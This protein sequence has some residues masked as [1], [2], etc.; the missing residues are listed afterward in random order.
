MDAG[1]HFQIINPIFLDSFSFSTFPL[2]P[3]EIRDEI[4][5][6]SLRH[7]R[8]INIHIKTRG[9]LPPGSETT[10]LDD[11]RAGDA[12]TNQRPKFEECWQHVDDVRALSKLMRVNREA[13]AC[14]LRFYR[15]HIPCYLQDRSNLGIL[16]LNPEN[17][18]INIQTNN[19]VE[20]IRFINKLRVND[21]LGIGPLNL[22]VSDGITMALKDINKLHLESSHFATF[23]DTLKNLRQVFFVPISKRSGLQFWARYAHVKTRQIREIPRSI[24]LMSATPSYERRVRDPRE[25]INLNA[26]CQI[27]LYSRS[28]IEKWRVILDAWGINHTT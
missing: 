26:I 20:Y 2:L 13:R 3:P 28:M 1:E 16:H 18:I 9:Y 17:D 11:E 12:S 24:P 21:P 6:F 22:T 4:W 25:D 10:L 7:P 8:L 14:A 19:A 23:V 15:V 5:Q 27:V